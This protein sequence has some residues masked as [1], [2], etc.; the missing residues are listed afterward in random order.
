MFGVVF[1][2]FNVDLNEHPVPE[3]AAA[4]GIGVVVAATASNATGGLIP[5]TDPSFVNRV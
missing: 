2:I 1:Y 3:T 4:A 5:G